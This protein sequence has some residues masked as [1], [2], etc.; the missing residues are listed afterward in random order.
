M[1]LCHVATVIL[2]LLK[3]AWHGII[4]NHSETDHLFLG[5]PVLTVR[6]QRDSLCKCKDQQSHLFSLRQSAVYV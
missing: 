3:F 5:A 2:Y 4:N 6:M 1:S